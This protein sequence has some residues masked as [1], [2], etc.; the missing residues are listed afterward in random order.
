MRL[1]FYHAIIAVCVI[2]VLLRKHGILNTRVSIELLLTVIN[3]GNFIRLVLMW[4]SI[5]FIV[6]QNLTSL[7]KSNRRNVG[8]IIIVNCYKT[9]FLLFEIWTTDQTQ[10]LLI[11]SVRYRHQDLWYKKMVTSGETLQFESN[12]MVF[13]RPV[14]K[15]LSRI[16]LG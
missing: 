15:Q 12:K 4:R 10:V 11:L 7:I 3:V 13:S 5:T 2:T 6:K 8:H 1:Y 14:Q 16:Q 9:I